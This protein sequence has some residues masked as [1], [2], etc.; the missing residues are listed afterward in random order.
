M[1]PAVSFS[2]VSVRYPTGTVAL[3]SV[4]LDV[5]DGELVA[6]VGPSGCGKSTALRLAAGLERPTDGEVRVTAVGPQPIAFVFQDATLLPWR[7]I[8][9]N[10]G[11]PLEL[12][13]EPATAVAS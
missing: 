8:R 3:S 9:D 10:V 11:L 5:A 4:D 12:R 1:P 7:R 2:R 6:I 13:G